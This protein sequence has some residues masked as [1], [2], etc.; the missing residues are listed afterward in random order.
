MF[1][2]KSKLD[3]GVTTQRVVVN[4][5]NAFQRP[6]QPFLGLAVSYQLVQPPLQGREALGHFVVV[7]GNADCPS[8]ANQYA[9][10]ASSCNC[11]IKQ[12]AL[13]HH[14]VLGDDWHDH[15][16]KF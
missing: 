15:H 3:F 16:R 6:P 13:Q 2:K 11:C 9:Q 5:P 1:F 12:V 8:V 7:H 4:L 10:V 14:V